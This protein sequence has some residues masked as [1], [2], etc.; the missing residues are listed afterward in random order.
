[1]EGPGEMS[2]MSIRDKKKFFEQEIAHQASGEPK[3]KGGRFLLGFIC[4]YKVKVWS[5][6]IKLGYSI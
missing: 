6:F 2:A 4:D 1:M 3:K 5:Q